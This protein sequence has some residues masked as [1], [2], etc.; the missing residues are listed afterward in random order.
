MALNLS[1]TSICEANQVR[2]FKLLFSTMDTVHIHIGDRYAL[3][4]QH[5]VRDCIVREQ[6]SIFVLIDEMEDAG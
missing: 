3:N 5:E 6:G 1:T 4:R 2:I